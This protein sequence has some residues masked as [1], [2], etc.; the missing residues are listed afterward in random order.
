MRTIKLA[1]ICIIFLFAVISVSANQVNETMLNNLL[2]SYGS[3][4]D[5]GSFSVIFD[6]AGALYSWFDGPIG[7]AG[8]NTFSFNISGPG[9]YA[10]IAILNIPKEIGIGKWI[11]YG[12]VIET[13]TTSATRVKFSFDGNYF[14]CDSTT[15]PGQ[16]FF[17]D[18]KIYQNN[19]LNYQKR[20]E[21]S[22]ICLTKPVIFG[23]SSSKK[24]KG[25]EKGV[26]DGKYEEL[27]MNLTFYFPENKTTKVGASIGDN[28]TSF[29]YA[30]KTIDIQSSPIDCGGYWCF[31]ETISFRYN[32]SGLKSFELSA[33]KILLKSVLIND[34]DMDYWWG[35]PYYNS[36][37][38]TSTF[39]STSS[40]NYQSIYI[41]SYQFA[42]SI[43]NGKIKTLDVTLNDN[44][45]PGPYDLELSLENQYGELILV[46]KTKNAVFPATISFN[47]TEIYQSKVNGPYRLG[48]IRITDLSG[49]ELFYKTNK[50][51]SKDLTYMNFTSPDMPD[52]EINYSDLKS[53]GTNLNV[54]IHN[55]GTGDAVGITVSVFDS[56]AEKIREDII[57][58]VSAKVNHTYKMS[59]VSNAAFVF[60]DFAN[61]V[62]ESNES[63]NAASLIPPNLP[64]VLNAIGDKAATENQLLTFPISASDPENDILIYSAI[65][66]PSG[67]TFNNITRIFNWI[68]TFTQA[69]IYHVLFKVT[70]NNT[71]SDRENVTITAADNN[72]PPIITSTPAGTATRGIQ[73]NYTIIAT[74]ADGD[75]LTYSINDSLF[76][77]AGANLFIWIPGNTRFGSRKVIFSVTDGKSA[78]ILQ[79]VEIKLLEDIYKLKVTT[80][81][82]QEKDAGRYT[83]IN[84]QA[85]LNPGAQTANS[86]GTSSANLTANSNT[87]YT[88]THSANNYQSDSD[89]VYFDSQLASCI[90]GQ[91]C[92]VF[93]TNGHITTC[94]WESSKNNWYC[95]VKGGTLPKETWFRYERT[96]E[97]AVKRANYLMRN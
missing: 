6:K 75:L 24:I 5:D 3:D 17:V 97:Q 47:G 81:D 54:T 65:G 85:T 34:H 57:S 72:Q 94:N 20:F 29:T 40:F 66:L 21:K 88:I 73:Y 84:S 9:T 8:N 59:G 74:D 13:K 43:S 49:N 71:N 36:N 38:Q 19:M 67:A 35:I 39:S 80:L 64:P 70:D 10:A 56:G 15:L 26:P 68:P 23:Y 79:Q 69:G 27:E 12:N 4:Y 93:N 51:L 37:T 1:G 7:G 25:L 30:E 46:N 90:S 28:K 33:E 77:Q 50:G 83:Y 11:E 44:G 60:I 78:P 87:K 2:D 14:F 95:S 32:T 42:E 18:L 82:Y 89:D 58:N 96:P 45:Y 22:Y 61:S 16:R 53:A 76:I 31:N 48:F 63:N 92:P 52:L 55:R 62:E 86:V 91:N 41:N